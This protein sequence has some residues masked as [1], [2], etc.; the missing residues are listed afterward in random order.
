MGRSGNP[1][2]GGGRGSG[3][4]GRGKGGWNK[5]KNSNSDKKET[6]NKK[7]LFTLLQSTVDVRVSAFKTTLKK[8]YQQLMKDIKTYPEDV[9]DS[10]K[11]KKKKDVLSKVS[12]KTATAA[13]TTD[14]EKEEARLK[15]EAFKMDYVHE[16]RDARLRD[17]TLES[18]LRVAYNIIFANFCDK[19]LQ[20]RLEHKDN[21]TSTIENDPFELL[22]AIR[23]MMH[24]TSHKEIDISI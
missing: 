17:E 12:L 6:T 1:G 11:A 14:E 7:H 20:N 13:G 9:V 18:N 21:F 8:M 10:L 15:N 24:T 23:E 3:R 2:R 22:S 16:T 5:K 19:E 4:G